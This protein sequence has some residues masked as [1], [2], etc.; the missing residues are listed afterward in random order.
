MRNAKFIAGPAKQQQS[1]QTSKNSFDAEEIATS[2]TADFSSAPA[3]LSSTMIGEG[4]R[5][6][7]DQRCR[8]TRKIKPSFDEG[9][10]SEAELNR[11]LPL[12]E[13]EKQMQILHDKF[14]NDS[15]VDAEYV[16]GKHKA[17]ISSFISP[18]YQSLNMPVICNVMPK[19]V[20]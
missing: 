1:P 11:I 3:L 6:R 2:P 18:S 16:P 13:Q 4:N 7:I 14:S 12:S 15:F 10:V 19:W 9:S 17:I 20:V 8:R 5:Y